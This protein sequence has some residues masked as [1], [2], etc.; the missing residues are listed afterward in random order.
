M[1]NPL[2]PRSVLLALTVG[3]CGSDAAPD[4]PALPAVDIVMEGDLVFDTVPFAV[5]GGDKDQL[6]G[7]ALHLTLDARL[8]SDGRLI[9]ATEGTQA[10]QF[11]DSAGNHLR[12]AGGPGGGP[13]E[14]RR[15]RTLHELA[16]DTIAVWDAAGRRL[17]LFSPTYGVVST[18][19]VSAMSGTSRQGLRP[20]RSPLDMYNMGD[21][22]VGATPLDSDDKPKG[23]SRE[24]V[25]ITLI[26]RTGREIKRMDVVPGDE[27]YGTGQLAMLSPYSY[28]FLAA[29]IP[30]AFYV[31]SGRGAELVEYNREGVANRALRLPIERRFMSR[32]DWNT[33]RDRFLADRVSPRDRPTITSMME[34]GL[35]VD[36]FPAFTSLE[37]A[38][39]GTL[40]LQLYDLPD[41]PRRFLV[42]DPVQRTARRIVLPPESKVFHATADKV[43]LLIRDEMDREIVRVHRF[44]RN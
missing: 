22:F 7:H 8:L 34:N 31:G 33:V 2:P 10:L 25:L 30:D 9:V 42:V 16:G 29:G 27:S 23:H 1:R 24:R 26:D 40:W 41:E 5:V 14:F 21:V 28:R 20:A 6:P 38:S 44:R 15:I 11:Y 43:V 3:A 35:A 39:D 18:A 19:N 13:G 4:A 17:S 32:A 36:S 12:Q 37:S